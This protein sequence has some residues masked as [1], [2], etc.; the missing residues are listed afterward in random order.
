MI[1]PQRTA[2]TTLIDPAPAEPGASHA[3]EG[4]ARGRV[5]GAEQL[6]EDLRAIDAE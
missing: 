5:E 4:R 2:V 3:P 1:E 6:L